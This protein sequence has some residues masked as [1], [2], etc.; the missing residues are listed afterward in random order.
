M[1][2]SVHHQ[3]VVPMGLPM[4]TG[5]VAMWFFLVTEIMFFTA[6]I[7]VYILLRH[8]TPSASVFK[9]PTPHQV[10]LVEWIG[11]LNTFVL[12][13][14]SLTVVLAH[15][16]LQNKNYKQATMYVGVTL[17]LGTVF[18][19]IKG[20]EYTAKFQHDILP[21]HIG[22]LVVDDRKP[23]EDDKD[24]E[25]RLYY[26]RIHREKQYHIVGMQY[27]NRVLNQLTAIL[28]KATGKKD[29]SEVTKE[30]VESKPNYI[31]ECYELR[32]AM[33]RQPEEKNDFA[34]PLSPAEVGTRTNEIL[35]EAEKAGVTLPLSPAIPFGNM[36]ASCYFAMTGFHALHVLGGLVIFVIML[37]MGLRNKLGP[38]HETFLELTGL[39]WHFVDIVWI[40]LFPLLYLV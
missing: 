33:V 12:I 10:H 19:I 1:A 13:A 21:G 22:E 17:A 6:L 28:V 36:W 24:E 31:Q 2:H 18:L 35:E 14:S 26:Q 29:V 16:A 40:F 3:N 27:S 9:W 20:F 8:G 5:K 30:D 32:E 15:Y 37:S 7:G 25:E 39:Y 23:K 4:P 34:S 11:A 38:Q